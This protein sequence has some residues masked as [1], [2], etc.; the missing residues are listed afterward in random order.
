MPEFQLDLGSPETAK[1]FQAL[2]AFTQGYI[3]ALFFTDEEQLC[4]ESGREMPAVAINMTTMETRFVGG[5]SPGFGDLAPDTLQSIVADCQTF[6]LQNAALLAQAYARNYDAE[7]AGR[8][9]WYTRNGHG[10]GYW[11]RK[12]LEPES[13]E[14]ELRTAEMIAARDDNAAWSAALARR[15]LI[16]SASLG[17]L[18]STA[19]KAFRGVD[20]YVGDDGLIYLS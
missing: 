1:Q 6:Q 16:E 3:E 2:D 18:L 20:S 4:E 8:D 5:D 17:T 11:D 9:F 13:A 12:E 19:A 10:V 7:Q 14:Y 15:K